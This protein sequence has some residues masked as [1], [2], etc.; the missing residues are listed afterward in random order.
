MKDHVPVHAYRLEYSDSPPAPEMLWEWD[1][2]HIDRLL[3]NA[4]TF[5]RTVV[6]CSFV[7]WNAL[8]AA[9]QRIWTRDY[10]PRQAYQSWETWQAWMDEYREIV[11]DMQ[12][13]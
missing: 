12:D 2:L 1:T 6:Q 11:R 13:I 4:L 9:N 5:G 3:W 10:L 7:D 8:V